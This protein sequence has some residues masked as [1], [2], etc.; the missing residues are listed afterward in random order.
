MAF[1]VGST[2]VID[3]NAEV[4]AERVD[5]DGATAETSFATSDFVLIYDASANA[6][7]KGTIANSALVGP[8]GPTG[9]TGPQGNLGPTGPTGPQGP[10]GNNG[11]TGPTGP[12]GSQGNAGPPGSTGPTGPQGNAGP[13]GPT[14]PQ[15]NAGPTGPTG[16]GG[17]VPTGFNSAG[18]P[19][20]V[21]LSTGGYN[22]GP[23]STMSASGNSQYT[24]RAA[25]VQDNW[26]V[27]H[28][29]NYTS[30][31]WRNMGKS[32]SVYETKTQMF[33][34]VS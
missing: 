24:I 23:G 5:I 34:R 31:T 9:S 28:G 3:T 32:L 18:A 7:R 20:M 6:I 33:Q 22:L 17:P 4:V 21:R 14:G 16:P 29:P 25:G 1:K 26:T 2:T 19:V 15:G 8:T 12:T 30:G 13:T 11:A 27:Q 10:A